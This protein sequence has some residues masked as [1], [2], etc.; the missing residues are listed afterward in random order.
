MATKSNTRT[1]SKATQE[2]K[3]AVVNDVAEEVVES[4]T[5]DVQQLVP[6]DID[7][8]QYV[9]VR[10]GFQGKLVYKSKRTGEKYVWGAFGDEQEMTLRELRNAKNSYKTFFVNNYFMFDD[11]WVIDYLGIKQYYKNAI[12]IDDFD[13]VFELPANELRQRVC[14]LSRGQRLSVIYRA[15]QLILDG[16]IDSRKTI[17]VLEEAL[18][19][20]LVER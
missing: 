6:K 16:K 17:Q 19:V 5:Q 7:P 2:K 4:D 11:P 1:R 3:P 8:E 18:G 15:R 20:E 10:N 13:E 14:E 12:S 9:I